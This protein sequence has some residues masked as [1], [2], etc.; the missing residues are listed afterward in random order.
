MRVEEVEEKMIYGVSTRT[1]NAD[2][3]NLKTAKIGAL[4][5][6]FDSTIEVDYKGG[7]RVY[8]V[9]Y[10]YESD[11]N[12]EFSVLTG[13]ET[14]NDQLDRV[15]IEKGRYLVFD[16][17]F[18]KTDDHTRVQAVIETW[19]QIWK[20]FSEEDSQYQRA[21]KSDFEYYRQIDEIEI[22]ISII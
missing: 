22:Y 9:Y 20:Y 19:G 1:K 3:M 4:W 16:K 10:D 18:E 5:Q 6:R 12:G 8:G 15:K 21:Y 13:Y 14:S 2:E 11:A 17:R 7:E